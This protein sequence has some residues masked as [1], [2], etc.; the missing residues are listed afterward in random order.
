MDACC[1][2][3]RKKNEFVNTII[4]TVGEGER[5]KRPLS[6]DSR[7]GKKRGERGGEARPHFSHRAKERERRRF[8]LGHVVYEETGRGGRKRGVCWKRSCAIYIY[9]HFGGERRNQPPQVVVFALF[10]SSS[11]GEEWNGISNYTRRKRKRR[12]RRKSATSCSPLI[13]H[14]HHNYREGE[15]RKIRKRQSIPGRTR[16]VEERM[17]EVL[18]PI[19]PTPNSSMLE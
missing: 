13:P 18:Q 17:D 1:L 15:E 2:G 16:L 9:L 14:I 5:G 8:F 19:T 7:L 11:K 12:K 10:S 3:K 6:N 4:I